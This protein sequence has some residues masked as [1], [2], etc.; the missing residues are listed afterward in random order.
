MDF[1]GKLFG[2][3]V[4]FVDLRL[5]LLRHVVD[6]RLVV[7]LAFQ[8]LFFV[9]ESFLLL[10]DL[11]CVLRLLFFHLLSD[12]LKLLLGSLELFILDLDKLIRLIAL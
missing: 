5:D 1:L 12:K 11:S 8:L 3:L 2:N 7:L 4:G 9:Q 6:E 10:L